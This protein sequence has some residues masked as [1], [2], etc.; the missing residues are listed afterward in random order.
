MS[1]KEKV[2]RIKD[3]VKKEVS[4][5]EKH[6]VLKLVVGI[7]FIIIGIVGLITPFTPD[8][9]LLIIGLV[10]I[11]GV[12]FVIHSLVFLSPNLRKKIA[13]KIKSWGFK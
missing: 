11:F 9:S 1:K 13:K 8:I 7:I 4:F 3:N 6:L 2:N 12:G 10:L 5:I